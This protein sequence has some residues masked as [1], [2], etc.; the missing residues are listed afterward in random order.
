MRRQDTPFLESPYVVDYCSDVLKGTI[1]QFFLVIFNYYY[2]PIIPPT[3]VGTAADLV[4]SFIFLF[5][6]C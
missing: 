2:I 4:K 1:T 5:K 3:D 6:L